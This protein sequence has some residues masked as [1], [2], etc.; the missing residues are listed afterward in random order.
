MWN[1]QTESRTRRAAMNM[2]RAQMFFLRRQPFSLLLPN[3]WHHDAS[4]CKISLR[5]DRWSTDLLKTKSARK[6]LVAE[7][8]WRGASPASW[9]TTSAVSPDQQSSETINYHGPIEC[10]LWTWL[11]LAS[12]G[13][14]KMDSGSGVGNGQGDPKEMLVIGTTIQQEIRMR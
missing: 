9:I 4:L 5:V 3:V 8:L 10:R 13:P 11:R 6:F 2:L 12:H 7:Y 1:N 14:W